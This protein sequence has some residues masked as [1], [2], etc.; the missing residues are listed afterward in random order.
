M[1][2]TTF[3]P[4]QTR[5]EQPVWLRTM[6]LYHWQTGK[7]DIEVKP[8]VPTIELVFGNHI[9]SDYEL[10]ANKLKSAKFVSRA[11]QIGNVYVITV[12]SQRPAFFRLSHEEEGVKIDGEFIKY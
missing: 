6:S 5:L 2:D 4:L 10:I 9:P 11:G 12:W 1:R 8:E 7:W 3:R